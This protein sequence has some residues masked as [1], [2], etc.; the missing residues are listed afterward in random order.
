MLKLWPKNWLAKTQKTLR[1]R[2]SSF[3]SQTG[4][5]VFGAT[6]L[7]IIAF[8]VM[9]LSIKAYF[10][11]LIIMAFSIMTLGITAYFTTLSIMTLST[12]PLSITTFRIMT[13]HKGLFCDPLVK[14]HSITI[15]YYYAE[16]RV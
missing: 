4:S 9:T 11:T 5:L 6:T 8:S 3:S 1:R 12:M 15:I 16:C 10:A 2:S 7:I 14:C 13:L